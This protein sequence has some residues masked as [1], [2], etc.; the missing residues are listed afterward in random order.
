MSWITRVV[1]MFELSWGQI[2]MV[3]KGQ[4]KIRCYGTGSAAETAHVEYAR[5]CRNQGLMSDMIGPEARDESRA[6]H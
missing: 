3:S 5:V 6:G 1:I 4:T 2:V